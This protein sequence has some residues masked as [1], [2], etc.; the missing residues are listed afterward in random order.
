MLDEKLK[1]ICKIMN[2]FETGTLETDYKSVYIYHDGPDKQRQV[3]LA[4]GFTEYG[5]N[6]RKVLQRYIAKG[7]VESAYFRSKLPDFGTG[8]L[9][10]DKEFIQKLKGVGQELA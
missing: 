8:K 5:G 9:V 3:T 2:V 10:D 6:L 1:L 7:G 4:R